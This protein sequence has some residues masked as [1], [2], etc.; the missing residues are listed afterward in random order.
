MTDEN[1]IVNL[2]IPWYNIHILKISYE[3]F[4]NLT[5]WF[6]QLVFFA[7]LDAGKGEKMVIEINGN[8]AESENIDFLELKKGEKTVTL[9]WDTSEIGFGPEIGNIIG[10]G[11]YLKFDDE[12]EETYGND[13]INEL[14]GFSLSDAQFYNF[15]TEDERIFKPGD[16]NDITIYDLVDGRE[17]MVEAIGTAPLS[18]AIR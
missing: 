9:T 12:E 14:I 10:H 18:Y 17:V 4:Y 3:N 7:L 11:V 8:M 2:I 6:I 16:I 1:F 5:D 15:K 13:R